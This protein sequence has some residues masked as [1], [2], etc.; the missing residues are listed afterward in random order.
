MSSRSISLPEFT[1]ERVIPGEVDPDLLNEHVARYAFAARVAGGRRV[2]DAGCGTGYGAAELGHSAREVV[3]IDIAGEA[4]EYARNHYQAANLRFE[5]ASCS[6]IPAADGSFD[7][8]VAFEIIEHLEDWRGFLREVRRVLA[9]QGL[10]LVSTPN[11]LYY[12]ESRREIGPNPYHRHE[13]EYAE[14][15]SELGAVFP[16][17]SVLMENHA[18]AIVFAPGKNTGSAELRLEETSASPEDGHFFLAVCSVA[19]EVDLP[20]FVYLPRVANMLREREKHIELLDGWL[21]KA[22]TDLDGL[23]D[24][25]RKQTEALEESN[26]WAEGLTDQ[27][28]ERGARVIALQEELAA[29][30]AKARERVDELEAE[31]RGAGETGRRLAEELER[32]VRE[33]A[34]CVDALHATERTLEERTAWAQKAQGELDALVRQI[35]ASAWIKI[36]RKLR[37][38]QVL[39]SPPPSG[40]KP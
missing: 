12:A 3:G 32:K 23:M 34:Q 11:K 22:K 6:E 30:Q 5:C 8:V 33:L 13:F 28:E 39:N 36:G 26:R 7:L 18:D 9:P 37:L 29:E 10:F 14:F 2:L 19:G 15:R 25:F 1:G 31:F 21:A 16:R 24:V 4:V 20:G 40:N 17:V 35:H 27:L 38:S